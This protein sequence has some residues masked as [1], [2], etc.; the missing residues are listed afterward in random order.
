MHVQTCINTY[1]YMYVHTYIHVYI[2]S[3]MHKYVYTYVHV[4]VHTHRGREGGLSMEKPGRTGGRAGTG[5]E[6]CCRGMP[7]CERE[8]CKEFAFLGPVERGTNVY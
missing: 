7:F 3:H 5:E 1:I 8:F 6:G 2:L 4:T